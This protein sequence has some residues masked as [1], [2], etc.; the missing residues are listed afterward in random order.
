MDRGEALKIISEL[1]D[2][3]LFRV[4][5]LSKNEKAKS[6]FTNAFMFQ[7]IKSFLKI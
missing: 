3:A 1:P 4:A 2:A 5:D 7:M 6:Y